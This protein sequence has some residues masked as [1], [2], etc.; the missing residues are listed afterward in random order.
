MG[1]PEPSKAL[2]VETQNAQT[3]RPTMSIERAAKIVAARP[4]EYDFTAVEGCEAFRV[5]DRVERAAPRL[6]AA[7]RAVL[8][9]IPYGEPGHVDLA[10]AFKMCEAAIADAEGGTHSR[11]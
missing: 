2:H 6:Y 7:C 5:M 8:G 9:G 3:P 10:T 11:N 4:G 1:N